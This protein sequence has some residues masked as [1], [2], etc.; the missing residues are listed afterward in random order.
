VLLR[1][2]LQR[3]T[4]VLPKSTNPGRI[5]S[6]LEIVDWELSAADMEALNG[7]EFQ[8]RHGCGMQGMMCLLLAH[9]VPVSHQ[10]VIPAV[11]QP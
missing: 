11:S 1:W 4:S 9:A 10:P 8:V 3:G 6:N 5:Q 2:G 7:L